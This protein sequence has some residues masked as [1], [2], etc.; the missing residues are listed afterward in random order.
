MIL[1]IEERYNVFKKNYETIIQHNSDEKRTFNMGINEF[2]DMT[3][4]EFDFKM[5]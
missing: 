3:E 1:D 2:C 5:I 4:E